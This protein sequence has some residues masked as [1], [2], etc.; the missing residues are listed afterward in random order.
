MLSKGR[1]VVWGLLA[2]LPMP[3]TLWHRLQYLAGLRKLGFEVWYVEDSDRLALHPETLSCTADVAPTIR[4]LEQS[5]RRIGMEDRWVYRPP[6]QYSECAG[7]LDFAGLQQLYRD[8]DLVIN[9]SA[10][11]EI[12]PHHGDI[13]QLALL[14]T[15]P[16]A[17]QVAYASGREET[18]RFLDAHHHLLTYASNLGNPDCRV[19]TGGLNWIPT[20][21]AICVDWWD[22]KRRPPTPLTLKTIAGWK[23][24]GHDVHWNG[25]SWRWSKHHEFRKF[26]DLPAAA[27]LPMELALV[28]ASEDERQALTARGW[29]LIR[30]SALRCADT[31]REYIWS[32]AGEFTVSKEQYV[33]PRSGWFSDRSATFLASGRPVVTQDTGFGCEL[34][35]GRG[36]F[37]FSDRG[38]ALSAIDLLAAD[39]QGQADAAKE[40]AATYFSAERVIGQALGRI[41]LL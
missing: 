7:A 37:A 39:Y 16:V 5:M 18:V 40:I 8:A 2:A 24:S 10:A 32:A 17:N 1:I 30:A 25:E 21:P 28:G 3:G 20:R 29:R 11:Q 38:E 9:H 12:L 13:R 22:G 15:D 33:A 34:P 31:Y 6:G 27:A 35:V 23:H 4:Y 26:M 36:L 19:P 14:E 41:G